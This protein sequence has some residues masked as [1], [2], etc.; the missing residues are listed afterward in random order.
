MS[1]F[2]SFENENVDF[3]F[4]NGKPL[5]STLDWIVLL[6]GVLLFMGIVSFPIVS[7]DN[8]TSLLFCLVVLVP[9]A[10]V[11]RGKLGLFFRRVGRKDIKLIIA[12]LVAYYVYSIAM[13]S[14]LSVFTASPEA[15][16]VFGAN[17]DLLFWVMT[18]IQ[19][20]GEELFKVSL[21]LIAMHVIY[22]ATSKRKLSL[23]LGVIIA[24]V[25][26]GL[27]HWNAYGGN[28][29][30]LILVIGLGGIFYFYAYIK[31]KNVAVSYIIHI[32]IDGIPFLMAM[33][34]KFAG[35]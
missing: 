7:D 24:L 23:V 8:M 20:L 10:Y 5:L 31:T 28:I 33:I 2:F 21:L 18:F 17:M 6:L 16:P 19:L 27:V 15:N 1:D 25:V 13:I 30:H 3:P 9:V 12:C 14:L 22:M 34:I 35:I 11:C 26:F 29:A 4:Y 32:L